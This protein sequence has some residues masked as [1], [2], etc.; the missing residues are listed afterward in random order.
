MKIAWDKAKRAI[1]IQC[2]DDQE[3]ITMMNLLDVNTKTN[4]SIETNEDDE[5]ST[6]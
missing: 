4:V 6:G 2:N 1:A 3:F 5:P